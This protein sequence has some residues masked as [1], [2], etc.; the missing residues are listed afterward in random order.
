M[1]ITRINFIILRPSQTIT[2]DKRQYKK[3]LQPTQAKL[4]YFP[5]LNHFGT[6]PVASPVAFDGMKFVGTFDFFAAAPLEPDAP[7]DE[8]LSGFMRTRDAPAPVESLS[9]SSGFK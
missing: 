2:N 3:C 8:S 7:P 5:G 6:A 9:K 4:R 1:E